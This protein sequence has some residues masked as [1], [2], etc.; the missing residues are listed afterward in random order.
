[1]NNLQ[2]LLEYKATLSTINNKQSKLAMQSFTQNTD[3]F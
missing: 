2:V 3:V 1:M